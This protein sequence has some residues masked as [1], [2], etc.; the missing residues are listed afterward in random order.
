VKPRQHGSRRRAR[1]DP[2]AELNLT[3][4]LN[5]MVV[6]LPFLLTTAVF[7]RLAVIGVDVPTPGPR[8][9]AAEPPPPP[10]VAPYSLSLRLEAD[11][12][13]VRSGAATL[14]PIPRGPDGA[15]D[16]GRLGEVLAGLKAGHPEH[17]TVD[18]FARP[19][20]PYAE[21]VGV[22]DAASFRPDGGALFANVRLGELRP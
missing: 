1:L 9:E 20:T 12:V 4:F 6:L 5:M 8:P 18:V 7:S 14:A 13:V 19:D 10:P 11:G 15:Y 16:T 17:D 21:L 22:M 2:E 3:A